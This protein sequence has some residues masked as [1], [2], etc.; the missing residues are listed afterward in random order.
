MWALSTVPSLRV[1]RYEGL[2][3]VPR[4]IT[5]GDNHEHINPLRNSC[6]N[7]Q[8]PTSTRRRREGAEERENL[9][10]TTTFPANKTTHCMLSN[11]VDPENKRSMNNHGGTEILPAASPAPKPCPA[12]GKSKSK[13]CSSVLRASEGAITQSPAYNIQ[14]DEAQPGWEGA[15]GC[16]HCNPGRVTALWRRSDLLLPHPAFPTSLL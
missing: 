14:A 16:C 6:Q 15:A 11:P 2:K 13:H 3:A 4:V 12:V 7:L 1:N 8:H 5:E 10:G 9:P